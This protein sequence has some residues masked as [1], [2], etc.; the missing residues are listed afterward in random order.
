M[1]LILDSD[2]H[3]IM[4][5]RKSERLSIPDGWVKL[6]MDDFSDHMA[7]PALVQELSQ[8]YVGIYGK[9]PS[10][11]LSTSTSVISDLIDTW[12]SEE[13]NIEQISY[14]ILGKYFFLKYFQIK[15]MT[16][17]SVSERDL[18]MYDMVQLLS[19]FQFG[20]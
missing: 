18:Y 11:S 8:G 13:V 9:L 14:K 3:Y 15:R 2:K 6:E 19:N 4:L 10:T 1:T 17:L 5:E 20:R 16:F 7:Y 12:N